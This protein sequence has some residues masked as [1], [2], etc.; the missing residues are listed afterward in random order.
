MKLH[1]ELRREHH[2]IGEFTASLHFFQAVSAA[3]F[4]GVTERLRELSTELDLPSPAPVQIF[5][6][7]VGPQGASGSA[8]GPKSALGF[9]RFSKEGEIAESLSCE[10]DSI[11]YVLRDY[12]VWEEVAPKLES[13]FSKLASEYIKEVPAILCNED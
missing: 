1:F 9:Q 6:F 3:T 10:A 4:T 13:I 12:T 11:T 8:G 2:A 5:E 7:T